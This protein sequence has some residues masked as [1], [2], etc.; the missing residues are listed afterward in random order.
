METILQQVNNLASSYDNMVQITIKI[1]S[2]E[3][4]S[5]THLKVNSN[6]AWLLKDLSDK[7]QPPRKTDV[8]FLSSDSGIILSFEVEVRTRLLFITKELKLKLLMIDEMIDI[9]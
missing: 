4:S 8:N 5:N 1:H 9:E 6:P 7:H 3:R 2:G